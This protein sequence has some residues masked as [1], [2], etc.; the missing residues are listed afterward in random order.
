[1]EHVDVK[2]N[3]HMGSSTAELTVGNGAQLAKPN[4]LVVVRKAAKPIPNR[5]YK[6]IHGANVEQGT[7]GMYEGSSSN[8]PKGRE[9]IK[10][11]QSKETSIEQTT[12]PCRARHQRGAYRNLGYSSHATERASAREFRW[13]VDL[14]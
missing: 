1:M 7:S 6:Y 13:K 9:G 8:I 2:V 14:N 11:T 3:S 5:D 10:S 12:A 4:T